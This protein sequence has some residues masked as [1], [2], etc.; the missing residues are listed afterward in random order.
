MNQTVYS[1]EGKEL[2]NI[3]LDEAVFGLPINEDVIWYAINNEL[4]T[5]NRLHKRPCGSS[6]FQCPAL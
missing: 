2:R 6:W 4:A 1:I 5:W 3:E